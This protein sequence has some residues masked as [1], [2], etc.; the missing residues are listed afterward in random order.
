MKKVVLVIFALI[1]ITLLESCYNCKGGEFSGFNWKDLSLVTSRT[2]SVVQLTGNQKIR[3]DSV[4]FHFQIDKDYISLLPSK[5]FSSSSLYACEPAPPVSRQRITEIRISS[6]SIYVTDSKSY[7]ANSDLIEIFVADY[8]TPIARFLTDQPTYDDFN[9]T[10]VTP[11]KAEQQ[12]EFT[13]S[14]K[15]DDGQMF[16]KKAR[17]I[18]TL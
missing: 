1:G 5:S 14:I 2:G 15:L 6:T 13:F 3:Y 8:K 10:I 9:F 18:L 4:R 17:L 12:H 16:E 7:N 11:P